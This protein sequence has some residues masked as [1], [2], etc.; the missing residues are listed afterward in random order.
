MSFMAVRGGYELWIVWKTFP[1]SCGKRM[2]QLCAHPALS[3]SSEPTGQARERWRGSAE[4]AN[5][6]DM[7]MEED[8]CT[9]AMAA[10]CGRM[11]DPGG[12]ML[13]ADYKEDYKQA[14]GEMLAAGSRGSDDDALS[15]QVET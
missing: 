8:R 7:L 11:R 9:T 3:A 15:A 13:R 12:G 5:G 10:G 6:W 14:G 4:V 2:D 1:P